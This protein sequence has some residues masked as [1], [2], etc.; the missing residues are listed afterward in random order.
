MLS[1]VNDIEKAKFSAIDGLILHKIIA[2]YVIAVIRSQPNTA[3]VIEP[4]PLLF[5]L[6]LGQLQPFFPPDPLLAFMIDDGA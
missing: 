1:F 3:V 4:Y 2:P 5:G 6:L